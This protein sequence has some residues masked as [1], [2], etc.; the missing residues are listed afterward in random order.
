[1]TGQN[2]LHVQQP[3]EE[4]LSTS[5]SAAPLQVIERVQ[6]EV[7]VQPRNSAL[8]SVQDWLGGGSR[9]SELRSLLRE[10]A[11]RYGGRGRV[12][13]VDPLGIDVTGGGGGYAVRGAELRGDV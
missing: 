2:R 11:Q 3:T 8:Q 7:D 5:N 1:M 4:R 13:N 12:H 6:G 10:P 9:L